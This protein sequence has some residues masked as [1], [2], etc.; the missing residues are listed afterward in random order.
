MWFPMHFSLWTTFPS[1]PWYT[2]NILFSREQ[3]THLN[4]SKILFKSFEFLKYLRWTINTDWLLSSLIW[5]SYIMNVKSLSSLLKQKKWKLM[6]EWFLIVELK[7]VHSYIGKNSRANI[8]LRSQAL[9]Q[10]T[11]V[12]IFYQLSF[13]Y[14][15]WP[16]RN[17]VP[18]TISPQP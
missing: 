9:R 8:T 4:S 16:L 17:V 18:Y 12:C 11:P 6:L 2:I 7:N 14:N 5:L 15:S 3:K 10:F 1:F 13:V